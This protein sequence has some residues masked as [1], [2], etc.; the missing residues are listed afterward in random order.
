VA[1]LFDFIV[2]EIHYSTEEASLLFKR[3]RVVY[4]PFAFKPLYQPSNLNSVER[5]KIRR[6]FKIFDDVNFLLSISRLTLGHKR[7]DKFIEMA[8]ILKGRGVKFKLL[9]VGDGEDKHRLEKV[10][11]DLLLNDC[12]IFAGHRDDLLSL[13]AA[14]DIYLSFSTDREVGIAGLQAIGCGLPVVALETLR[15]GKGS[16]GFMPF[17]KAYNLDDLAM[18]VENIINHREDWDEFIKNSSKYVHENYSA[19]RMALDYF[20]LYDRIAKYNVAPLSE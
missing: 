12:I 2:L 9:L 3:D 15:K 14:S 20:K 4:I 7:I 10:T 17:A 5:L 11:A 18:I 19:S 6:E 1:N 13:Y 16:S 8:G